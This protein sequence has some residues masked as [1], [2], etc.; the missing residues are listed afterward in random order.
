MV[1]GALGQ[2][3]DAAVTEGQ[4]ARRRRHAPTVL[5][6]RGRAGQAH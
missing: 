5:D 6:H 1:I 3:A 4:P 2:A